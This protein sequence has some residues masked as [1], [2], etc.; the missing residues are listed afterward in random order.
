[1]IQLLQQQLRAL[2][3]RAVP[4]LQAAQHL[5]HGLR[6]RRAA[7]LGAGNQGWKDDDGGRRASNQRKDGSCKLLGKCLRSSVQGVQ[8]KIYSSTPCM[9]SD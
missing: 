9:T 5:L 7:S 8:A 4:S 1:M 3:E 6:V 2:Q